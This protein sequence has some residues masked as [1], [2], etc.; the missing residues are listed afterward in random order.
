MPWKTMPICFFR[1]TPAPVWQIGSKKLKVSSH[2]WIR[3][4]R[5]YPE[6]SGWQEGYGAF[7]LA[8]RDR[9]RVVRYIQNQQDHHRAMDSLSEFK[10]MLI[11]AGLEW[12]DRHLV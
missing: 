5:N 8:N 12:D 4:R 10:E 9:E 2:H 7:S 1:F 6:F 3:D 11:Q